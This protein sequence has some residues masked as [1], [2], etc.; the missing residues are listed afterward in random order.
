MEYRIRTHDTSTQKAVKR[1]LQPCGDTL[2]QWAVQFPVTKSRYEI[3][4]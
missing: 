4:S 1:E 3:N 2:V